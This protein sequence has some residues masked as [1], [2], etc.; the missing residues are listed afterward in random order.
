[1]CGVLQIQ[2]VKALNEMDLISRDLNPIHSIKHLNRNDSFI[3][4]IILQD[5]SNS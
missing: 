5:Y 1:V 2:Q 3:L 4:M